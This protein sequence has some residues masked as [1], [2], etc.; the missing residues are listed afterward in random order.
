M[1][2]SI[3]NVLIF[4][5]GAAVGVT[6][7]WQFMK[8]KYSRIA[9]EEIASVKE[10]Y[11][12]HYATPETTNEEPEPAEEEAIEFSEEEKEEYVNL[13]KNYGNIEK[14]DENMN[15]SSVTPYVIK[16][17]EFGT[18]EQYDA[19]SLTYYADKVLVDEDDHVIQDVDFMVGDDFADHFGEYEDDSVFIRND[20]IKTDFEIL[21][22]EANF[23]DE[24][25]AE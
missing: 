15:K 2:D 11:K 16:P 18:N 21:L 19:V 12:S 13:A 25:D 4:I 23:Y 6:A 14:G 9:D 3:K 17:E 24:D 10:T 22:D 20:M 7:S 1:G 8:N 5:A